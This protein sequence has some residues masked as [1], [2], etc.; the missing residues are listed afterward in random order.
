MPDTHLGLEV[1]LGQ[2]V[3]V[4]D[5]G[6]VV[7]HIAENLVLLLTSDGEGLL[8]WE[9]PCEWLCLERAEG[10]G[11]NCCCWQKQR[12]QELR[13]PKRNQHNPCFG[14]DTEKAPCIEHSG[15]ASVL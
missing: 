4:H 10:G 8:D 14:S 13:L 5:V 2:A 12:S 11:L 6:Q 15:P 7:Q 9:P 1:G 3:A